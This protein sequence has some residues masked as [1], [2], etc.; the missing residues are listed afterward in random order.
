MTT[1]EIE[2]LTI[3]A[4]CPDFSLPGIDGQTYSLDS[5]KDQQLL[6]VLFL[7]THCPYVGAWDDRI[8]AIP[9]QFADR[10]VGFVGIN[11]SDL[12]PEGLESMRQ[13]AEKAGYPFPYLQDTD[14][15]VARGFGATRTPEVFLF[16]AERRLAYHGAI[17]SDYEESAG[18]TNY[19]REALH[20]LVEGS[21]VDLPTTPP[22]G[23]RIKLR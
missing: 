7:S 12:G 22:V 16:N 9:R 6:V 18:M 2:T 3:G 15:S 10:G 21:T 4:R 13:R 20:R 8:A 17:D 11:S 23:C 5:F 1:Q 14:Q 19:L